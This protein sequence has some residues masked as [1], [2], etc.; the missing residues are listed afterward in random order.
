MREVCSAPEPGYD[1]LGTPIIAPSD[2]LALNGHD[3]F[4]TCQ[5]RRSGSVSHQQV[6]RGV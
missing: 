6:G 5:S 2:P 1:S 4:P 3:K